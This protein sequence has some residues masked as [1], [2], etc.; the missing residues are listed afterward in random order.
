MDLIRWYYQRRMLNAMVQNRWEEADRFTHRL[1]SHEGPSMGLQY[2][3]ALIALGRGNREEAYVILSEAVDRYGE[4]LR[5][6]R[7]LGDIA[8]LQ[9]ER[10]QAKRWYTAALQDNP[11]EKEKH[12][13]GL[14]LEL[15]ASQ[16]TYAR[17]LAA[18][19]LLPEAQNLLTRDPEQ[20]RS[21]YQRIVADDPSQAE[22]WNNLGHLALDHFSDP[23]AAVEAFN[24]TIELVDHQGAA[25]NLARAK[26]A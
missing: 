10:K 6:C 22:A 21:L 5:L 14:R 13:I 19:N 25:R 3:M 16:Q 2:N 23:P 18:C 24:R 8:Y 9:G 17:A 26:K 1:I 11:S 12:L 15:L 4:S 7:L 20:A